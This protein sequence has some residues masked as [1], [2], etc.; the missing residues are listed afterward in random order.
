MSLIKF[1]SSIPDKKSYSTKS[2]PFAFSTK[3][4]IY[5]FFELRIFE[6]IAVKKVLRSCVVLFPLENDKNGCC[7]DAVTAVNPIFST[8][9]SFPLLFPLNSAYLRGSRGS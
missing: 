9:S 3:I 6:Y 4:T 1:L 5:R 2:G 8:S 7:A